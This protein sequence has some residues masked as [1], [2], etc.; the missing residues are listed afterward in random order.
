MK[1]LESTVDALSLGSLLGGERESTQVR[2]LLV[3]A[4]AECFETSAGAHFMGA[5]ER[6]CAP[7][8]RHDV[9]AMDKIAFS[10]KRRFDPKCTTPASN[11]RG[12]RRTGPRD[13]KNTLYET[14]PK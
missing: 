11:V 2:R 1:A 3:A 8:P 9:N 14:E 7:R 12:I 6:D 10:A 5:L 13:F 4:G